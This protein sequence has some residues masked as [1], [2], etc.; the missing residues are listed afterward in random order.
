MPDA[1]LF[2]MGEPRR[3]NQSNDILPV[4][5]IDTLI[6]DGCQIDPEALPWLRQQVPTMSCIYQ[7]RK[8]AKAWR[9]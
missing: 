8:E 4:S 5:K 3:P 2:K 6:L 1:N 9:R 7:T